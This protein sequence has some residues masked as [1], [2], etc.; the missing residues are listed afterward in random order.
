M[1]VLVVLF[2]SLLIYRGIGAMGVAALETWLACAR[3]ALATMF[4]FTA[5]AHFTSSR[6]DMIAMVPPSFPQ[7]GLLVTISGSSRRRARL[8]CC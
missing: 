2:G 6:K 8:D 3:F 5:I 7:P 4:L 1:A